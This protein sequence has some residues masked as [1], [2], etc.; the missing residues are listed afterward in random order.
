MCEKQNPVLASMFEGLVKQVGG[1]DAAR[2]VIEAYVGHGVSKGTI[3]QIQ[4]AKAMVPWEWVAALENAAENLPFHRLRTNQLEGQSFRSGSLV[5]HLKIIKESA[6]AVVA[7]AEAEGTDCPKA[8]STSLKELRDL[9]DV[10]QERADQE[11]AR[12][13]RMGLEAAE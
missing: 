4:N 1:T 13:D 8:L 11:Q 3:S 5:S 10:A 2:A 9:I 12:L 6:E 7:A